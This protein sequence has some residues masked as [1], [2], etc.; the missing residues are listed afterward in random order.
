[1]IAKKIKVTG[2]FTEEDWAELVALI[3]TIEQRHPEKHYECWVEEGDS[4]NTTEALEM[5]QRTFVKAPDDDAVF[6][7]IRNPEVFDQIAKEMFPDYQ[8]DLGD[9]Q[10][11]VDECQAGV[12]GRRERLK[13]ILERKLQ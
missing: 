13:K 9:T 2:F 12:L 7:V 11:I 10:Q 1:M 5:L 3:R 6:G 4:V 8:W